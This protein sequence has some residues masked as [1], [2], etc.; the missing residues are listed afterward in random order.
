MTQKY[1][2]SSIFLDFI[3]ILSGNY[4]RVHYFFT[5]IPSSPEMNF[6]FASC[7]LVLFILCFFK[8]L[9]ST[10]LYSFRFLQDIKNFA[11]CY[12]RSDKS[13]LILKNGPRSTSLSTLMQLYIRN[14][15][16]LPLSKD[17]RKGLCIS[18]ATEPSHATLPKA[19]P[20]KISMACSATDPPP[21]PP[22]RASA[23]A[24]STIPPLPPKPQGFL[25][26]QK[27]VIQPLED[28][29]VTTRF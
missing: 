8:F 26:L 24:L 17:Q 9:I 13:W 15:I 29:P 16:K 25:T 1:N 7:T 28:S 20:R 19:A 11:I 14:R 10:I 4:Q 2:F 12:D 6:T 21:L 23:P 18:S 5:L 3:A 27:P 22:R